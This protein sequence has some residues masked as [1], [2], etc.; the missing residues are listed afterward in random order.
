MRKFGGLRYGDLGLYESAHTYIKQAY[1]YGSKR[2][3]STMTET[4]SAYV[5]EKSKN[6]IEGIEHGTSKLNNIACTPTLTISKSKVRTEDCAHTVGN[7]S[8]FTISDL[9]HGRRV[10]RKIRIAEEKGDPGMTE[11]LKGLLD[12]MEQTAK[13]FCLI[14]E[15]QHSEF[16]IMNFQMQSP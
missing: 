15:R 10:L 11:R 5:K 16:F 13:N 12:D 4:V 2:K 7:G 6:L 9:E 14:R 8:S 3:S 1:A